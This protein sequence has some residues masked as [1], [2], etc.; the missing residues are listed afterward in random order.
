M[1]GLGPDFSRGTNK[2]QPGEAELTTLPAKDIDHLF[3]CTPPALSCPVCHIS[4]SDRL[5]PSKILTSQASNHSTWNGF[6]M[7]ITGTS[8]PSWFVLLLSDFPPGVILGRRGNSPVPKFLPH[9]K[10]EALEGPA[11]L[12][13]LFFQR[14]P[15]T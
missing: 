10:E 5:P 3:L 8:Q 2:V 7:C 12:C 6:E 1:L 9:L 4:I 13:E 15:A 11:S 14:L